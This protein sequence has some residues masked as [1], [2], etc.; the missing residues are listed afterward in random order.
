MI[1][2]LHYIGDLHVIFGHLLSRLDQDAH[3]PSEEI[4][5][6]ESQLQEALANRQLFEYAYNE[7][8]S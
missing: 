4:G 2:F 6:L 5:A 1:M 3:R 7:A 8:Y